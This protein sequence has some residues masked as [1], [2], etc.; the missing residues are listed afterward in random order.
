MTNLTQEYRDTERKLDEAY[1]EYQALCGF[2][3]DAGETL[4][5]ESVRVVDAKIRRLESVMNI[6]SAHLGMLE[7][8]IDANKV[9]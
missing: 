6:L 7:A 3:E 1:D 2:L 4:S 8:D 9:K 5:E